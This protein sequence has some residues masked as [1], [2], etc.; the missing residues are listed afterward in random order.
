MLLASGGALM[1]GAL[2]AGTITW[3]M[4][5]RRAEATAAIARFTVPVPG[6]RILD[7]ATLGPWASLAM[8]R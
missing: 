7:I 2:I 4:S 3:L 5:H 8:S 1:V 6:V